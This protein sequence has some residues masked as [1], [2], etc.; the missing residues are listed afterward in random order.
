MIDIILEG[1]TLGLRN[2]YTHGA[3]ALNVDDPGC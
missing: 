1:G 3:L 2:F